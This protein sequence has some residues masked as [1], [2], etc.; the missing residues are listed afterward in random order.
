VQ[1]KNQR[2]IGVDDDHEH[3]QRAPSLEQPQDGHQ[4]HDADPRDVPD[5]RQRYVESQQPAQLAEGKRI[6]DGNLSY[7]IDSHDQ[8]N[9]R[10][11]EPALADEVSHASF[12]RSTS[13]I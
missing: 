2:S 3:Q 10:E 5:S 8:N 13:Q 1:Q 6:G 4:G 9:E 12:V 11:R 7:C